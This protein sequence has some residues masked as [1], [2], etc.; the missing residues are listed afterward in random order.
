MSGSLRERLDRLSYGTLQWLVF[1][2]VVLHNVE[3]VGNFEQFLPDLYAAEHG[4]TAPA[5]GQVPCARP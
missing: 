3:E 2:C 4:R 1:V 5:V